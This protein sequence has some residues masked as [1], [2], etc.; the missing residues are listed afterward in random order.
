M[1]QNGELEALLERWIKDVESSKKDIVRIPVD[2]CPI[3]SE[4]ALRLLLNDLENSDRH[5]RIKQVENKLFQPVFQGRSFVMN[6]RFD[7]LGCSAILVDRDSLNPS[8]LF[9]DIAKLL[10]DPELITSRYQLLIRKKY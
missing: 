8:S 1:V 4:E 5:P 3:H 9:T 6:E 2:N 10:F 7:I